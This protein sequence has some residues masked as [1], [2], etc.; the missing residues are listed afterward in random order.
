MVA[1]CL[2]DTGD[3]RLQRG[4]Q[5]ALRRTISQL[6]LPGRMGDR[7]EAEFRLRLPVLDVVARKSG[8]EPDAKVG[9]IGDLLEEMAD[10]AVLLESEFVLCVDEL[11]DVSQAEIKALAGALQQVVEESPYMLQ[12]VGYHSWAG[13]KLRTRRSLSTMW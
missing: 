13:A 2:L 11:H 5:R 3:G 6:D 10:L 12:L 7:W 4:L 9:D 1:V 8:A